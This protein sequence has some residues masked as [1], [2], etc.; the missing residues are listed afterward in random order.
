MKAAADAA[1]D[2]D[3]KARFPVEAVDAMREGGLLSASLPTQLGGGDASIIDLGSTARALGAACS[4]AAMVYAMHHTQALSLRYHGTSPEIAELTREIAQRESL[5]ASATTEITTGGDVRTSSCAVEVDG[6]TVTLQKNAPVIS[7]GEFADYICATARRSPDAPPSDQVLVVCPAADT[8]LE[9]TSTWNTLGFRG[10]CSPGFVLRSTT[11]AA[12]VVPVEYGLIS[13]HTMLPASHT[14]WSNVWLG[15]ADAAIAKAREQ[16]REATRRSPDNP[17]AQAARLADL[18]VTH[19]AFESSVNSATAKYQSF[20]ATGET[21]PTMAFA[22]AMNNLKIASSLNVVEVVAGA[23]TICGIN[24]YRE[25]H[26]ASMGRLLRDAYAPQLMVSND[27][28]RANNARLVLA[29][30]K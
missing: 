12:N 5:L 25:D 3:H 27:R 30:R 10:T 1:E 18:L 6:D 4:S 15:M 9:H 14:L 8:T 11:S 21:E 13:A 7:Y 17:P 22:L 29:V 20:L 19:Q 23:L 28:I 2:V 24:G 16:V 26:R